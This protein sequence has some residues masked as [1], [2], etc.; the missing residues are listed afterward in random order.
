MLLKLPE[1]LRAKLKEPLGELIETIPEKSMEKIINVVNKFKPTK[2]VS[3]GDVIT[4]YILM[5][6]I[7]PD[8]SIIDYKM[9]RRRMEFSFNYD[10]FFNIIVHTR[11]P[12]GHISEDAWNKIRKHI[13]SEFK[14]LIIVDGEEDLLTLPALIEAPKGSLIFY[15]QPNIGIVFIQVT[16][17]VKKKAREIVEKFNKLESI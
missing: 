3:I 16:D 10:H 6:G 12:P 5:S 15:G 17:E 4:Q 9:Y 8:L 2:V 1:E 11:N 7:L 14:T 13:K